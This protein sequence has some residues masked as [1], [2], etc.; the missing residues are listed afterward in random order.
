MKF[1]LFLCAC[2]TLSLGCGDDDST[3]VE[4]NGG[5]AG[6]GGEAGG[7]AGAGGE[8]G[9][10]AGAGGEAG[11]QAGA[12]G[13]AGGQAGAGGEAGGQAGAG[14]EAGGQ[15]GAGG[16]AGGQAGAGGEAGGQAGAGGEAGGQAGAGGEAGMMGNGFSEPGPLFGLFGFS[17]PGGLNANEF[18]I[19]IDDGT[20]PDENDMPVEYV[21]AYVLEFIATD[22]TYAV[23][24]D[25]DNDTYS[26][27]DF[28]LSNGVATHYCQASFGSASLSDALDDGFSDNTNLETGCG[29]AEFS[30]S[31]LGPIDFPIGF[32]GEDD[33]GTAVNVGASFI[34]V[35]YPDFRPYMM[36]HARIL[37]GD[38]A[39]QYVA[40]GL[41][42][43]GN[44]SDGGLWSRF[45]LVYDNNVL[46]YCQSQY[47]ALRFTDA[48]NAD[49]ADA[50]NL[51]TGCGSFPW[52]QVE[53]L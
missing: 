22:G 35:A 18:V 32:S 42:D 46:R 41:N 49:A 13:E 45:D 33:M 5:T 15:A 34:T 14:G 30:F 8:A 40:I 9:G 25:L 39:G 50:S 48:L 51:E 44:D 38:T 31:A 7:Q 11:G 47:N 17:N 52:S 21:S 19:I 27:F 29:E 53:S 2:L 10:Q 6:A 12:G 36:H 20:F 1:T 3:N 37:S 23:G 4:M 26:L 43:I 24:R 16:E 28:A